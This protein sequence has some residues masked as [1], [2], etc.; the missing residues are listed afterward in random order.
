[1]ACNLLNFNDPEIASIGQNHFFDRLAIE[2]EIL[3]AQK[4]TIYKPYLQKMIGGN[5]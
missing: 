3:E 5:R 4:A 2:V 1:M